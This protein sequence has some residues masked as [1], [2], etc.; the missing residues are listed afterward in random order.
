MRI[1]TR[2]IV[3]VLAIFLITVC[4]FAATWISS[5]SQKTDALEINLAGRQRMLAQKIAKIA[6]HAGFVSSDQEKSQAGELINGQIR[7]FEQTLSALAQ[8]GE[9][10]ATL[11]AGGAMVRLPAPSREIADALEGV[12]LTWNSFKQTVDK[13]LA[14]D[15]SASSGLAG[16]T[17]GVVAAMD[18]VVGRMADDSEAK[19]TMLLSVQF[20]GVLLGAVLCALIMWGMRRDMIAPLEALRRFTGRVAKGDMDAGIEGEFKAE[21][22]ELKDSVSAMLA[23]LRKTMDAAAQKGEEAQASALKAQE[24]LRQAKEQE[25]KTAQAL[26]KL[27]MAA[28]KAQTISENSS[29]TAARLSEQVEQVTQGAGVQRDRMTETAAAMREM[30]STVMDVARNAS[31]A[32][33]SAMR[34]RER[35]QTGAEG[36]QR[37][38]ASIDRIQRQI[39]SLKESMGK[40]GEQADG[41]GHV[42]NVISDIADQTNLLAL[43]AAIEAARAGEA[44]RGFAV[45]ADEVRKLAEKTMSATK[46]VG[47][48][49]ES[50]QSQAQ[51]NIE[52]VEAAAEDIVESAGAARESGSF[53]EEI[54]G[55]VEESARQVESIAAASEEQSAASEEINRAVDEV[56]RIATQTADDMIQAARSVDALSAL[57]ESLR[58]VIHEMSGDEERTAP[59]AAR[60]VPAASRPRALGEDRKSAPAGSA[61]MPASR[62]ALPAKAPAKA[63]TAGTSAGK[64]RPGGARSMAKPAAAKPSL[65]HAKGNGDMIEW[66][67]DLVLGIREIDEQHKTLVNMINALHKAMRSGKGS[68]VLTDLVDKLAEYSVYHFSAEEKLMEKCG[69]GGLL[70][71]RGQH[72]RFVKKVEEFD[73]ELH[74][75][76]AAVTNEVM[77]FLK[78]WLVNHIQGTDRKYAPFLKEHGMH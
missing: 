40:L 16:E 13:A 62:K 63:L 22:L 47:E 59:F 32:A 58:V 76:K 70:N 49:V 14:G 52:A 10:P 17:D 18:A 73:R 8:G 66:N 44:G 54:V 5:V 64:A 24:S 60:V 33:Q 71:H 36:A 55:I 78:D 28:H 12:R 6:L 61:L 45:V 69:Y 43:N 56:D 25:T 51:R 67:D 41:I 23:S 42:M 68:T 53:M 39:I 15:A 3:S 50:I 34:A 72:E 27:S 19:V 65:S 38:A 2:L 9:A 31:Q 1:K 4:M 77:V 29:S 26:E 7:I 30:N 37:A 21:F 20:V 46:E 75:G 35:A 11:K 48:A 57:A 74:E